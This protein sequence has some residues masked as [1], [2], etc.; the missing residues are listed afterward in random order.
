MYLLTVIFLPASTLLIRFLL[1]PT[2][3]KLIKKSPSWPP[4]RILDQ[5]TFLYSQQFASYHTV[6]YG[7]LMAP[8]TDI[9]VIIRLRY[10]QQNH[11]GSALTLIYIFNHLQV[12]KTSHMWPSSGVAS[13]EN[14]AAVSCVP[15]ITGLRKRLLSQ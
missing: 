14:N 9:D 11:T 8:R 7:R 5:H 3:R 4:E 10:G 15:E 6:D 12:I 13:I 1:H 2:V